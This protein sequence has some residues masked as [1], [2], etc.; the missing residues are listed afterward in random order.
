MPAFPA[1]GSSALHTVAYRRPVDMALPCPRA[2]QY[3]LVVSAVVHIN[4]SR[5][6]PLYRHRLPAFIYQPD[7][8]RH[9]V[10]TRKDTVGKDCL[11]TQCLIC[12]HKLQRFRICL[13][14]PC[15]RQSRKRLLPL[16]NPII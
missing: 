9:R 7:A 2:M 1:Q 6:Y 15:G 8:A 3:Y 14:A 4:G 13:A 16:I 12:K 10:D 11:Y 5:H